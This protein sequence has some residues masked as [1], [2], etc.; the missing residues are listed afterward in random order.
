MT[1]ATL[2][3]AE[4]AQRYGISPR[5]LADLEA[6]HRIPVLRFGRAV[7]YDGQALAA[8]EAACRC[9]SASRAARTRLSGTSPAPSPASVSA[10]LRERLTEGLRTN[11]ARPAKRSSTVVPFTAP[12]P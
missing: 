7:R 10:R 8:L 12:K 6:E 11:T 9:P 3:R 2:T 1:E 4:A 5:H